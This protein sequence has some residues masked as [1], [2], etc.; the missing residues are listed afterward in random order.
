VG[1]RISAS[2]LVAVGE[3]L[4]LGPDGVDVRYIDPP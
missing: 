2:D 1:T 4:E 3:T